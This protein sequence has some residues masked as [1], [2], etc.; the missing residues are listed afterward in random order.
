MPQRRIFLAR[1]RLDC[2]FKRG[3]VPAVE[4]PPQNALLAVVG[5]FLDR[6]VAYHRGL[7]DIVTVQTLPL[8]QFDLETMRGRATDNDRIYFP[9]KLRSQFPISENTFYYKTAPFAD[10]FT[11]DPAGWGGVPFIFASC[12]DGRYACT[13]NTKAFAQTD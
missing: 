10:Y 1:P 11:V 7:G 9:H 2:S 6:L 3:P 12:D 8:W 4:G 5:E 13:G